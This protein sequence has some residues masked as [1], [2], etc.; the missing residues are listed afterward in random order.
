MSFCSRAGEK[1]APAQQTKDP[2]GLGEQVQNNF[3]LFQDP[4][5]DLVLESS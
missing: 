1:A 4:V 3:L 2:P 5:L